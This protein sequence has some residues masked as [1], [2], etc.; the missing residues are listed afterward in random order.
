MWEQPVTSGIAIGAATAA[1]LL[2]E[3]SGFTLI[4]LVAN[5]LLL[6][7]LSVFVW[8][9][10]ATVLN[11]PAPPLQSIEIDPE[12]S[13]L[14][15]EKVTASINAVLSSIFS[16]LLGKDAAATLKLAFILYTVGK[17]GSYFHSVTLLYIITLGFFSVPKLYVLKKK[18]IDE[19]TAV[20]MEH[21]NKYYN[22]LKAI[23]LDK[24]KA[25]TPKKKEAKEPEKTDEKKTK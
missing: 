5:L 11:L 15:A 4:A 20:A 18:E 19:V 3:R 17:V 6:G 2:L 25:L 9:N 14:L 13:K 8:S 10:V 7:V 21:I 16:V 12:Q 22:I 23:V 1:F 24:V